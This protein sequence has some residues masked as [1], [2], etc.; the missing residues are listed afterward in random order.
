MENSA[1]FLYMVG[2]IL[3]SLIV[4]SMGVYMFAT[5]SSMNA[6]YDKKLT[7]EELRAYNAEFEKYATEETEYVWLATDI[8]TLI[9][10]VCDINENEKEQGGNNFITINI[11]NKRIANNPS[12]TISENYEEFNQNKLYTFI[13]ENT[14]QEKKDN[15][16]N[17]KK[18]YYSYK[19]SCS[20]ISYYPNGKVKE[21]K[22]VR[23]DD[24]NT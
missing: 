9:N 18:E 23:E 21:I 7:D 6:E 13:Q 3:I 5:G 10:K 4:I 17:G 12:L 2:G 16:N 14:N 11:Y 22:F 8:V 19:F 15:K 20:I 24:R 1:K